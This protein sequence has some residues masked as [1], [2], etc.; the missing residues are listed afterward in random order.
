[1]VIK[2]VAV[3]PREAAPSWYTPITDE[4]LQL[5]TQRIVDAFQPEKIILFGSYAYGEPR[6]DSDLDL[7]VVMNRLRSKRVVER[8]YAVAQVA[9]PDWLA[10][11]I[12]VRTPQE[13]A[14]RLKIG[15]PFFQEITTRGL[16]LYEQQRSRRRMGSG[17]RSG[18]PS[19]ARSRA[20]A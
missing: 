9:N 19:R 14:Y 15:D 13:I 12:M 3:S 8:D 1:M 6:M 5:V 10:M 20:A 2:S 7:L 4:S 11:D 16:V 18:L 17:S